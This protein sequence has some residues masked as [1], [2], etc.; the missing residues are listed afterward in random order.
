MPRQTRPLS[1]TEIE[2]ARPKEKLYRL[3]DG[4]GLVL[5]ITPN[6]GKYWYLQYK[7]PV[8]KKAQMYKLGDYPAVSL[9]QAR[10]LCMDCHKLLGQNID[11]KAY[12]EQEIKSKQ[13]QIDNDFKSVFNAWI[14]TKDYAPATLLKLKTY[15]AELLAVIGNKP[16]GDISVVECIDVLRP[17]ERAGHL[18]KLKKVKSMMSQTFAYAV[19]TGKATHNPVINL[20]G[21]FK[22]AS[23]KHNPAIL[24][25]KRLSELVQEMDG[26]HGSFVVKKCLMFSLYTFARQGEIRN[27]RFGDVNFNDG[28]WT[29]MPSKTAKS[30]QVNVVTP[31]SKQALE[32]LR[33]L[34]EYH[35]GDIVFVSPNTSLKPVSDGLV[36]RALRRLGFD[37]DEQTAHGFRAIARTLL[38][39]K[40]KYDYRMIEMQLGHQVRDSNGRAYNRVT[41]LGE[42]REMLQTWADYI[43]QLKSPT[44]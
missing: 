40:F 7:H 34:R 2:K 25:E 33:Q 26:Y 6:G 17:I 38:E 5:N 29:Y 18:E 36:N 41:W 16:I 44:P 37:K 8:T 10:T 31:L 12:A 4:N 22:T 35:Q 30:T 9:S 27:M 32:I 39:E 43:D 1:N 11:P 14:A 28:L 23:K 24:D 13:S 21:V 42:R 3:Y 19:A 15:M 20:T